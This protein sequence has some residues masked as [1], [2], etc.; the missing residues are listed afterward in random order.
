MTFSG[1]DDAGE[2]ARLSLK[3]KKSDID[4]AAAGKLSAKEFKDRVARSSRTLPGAASK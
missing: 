3:A 1:I 4:Q 2:P